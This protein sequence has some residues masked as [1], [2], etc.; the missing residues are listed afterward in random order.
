MYR[1]LDVSDGL[2]ADRLQIVAETRITIEAS[3]AH[4]SNCTRRA[5]RLEK[6]FSLISG[7]LACSA[8]SVIVGNSMQ[9]IKT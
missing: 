4:L 1:L 9:S 2:V 5:T 3:I 8:H 6:R 7:E